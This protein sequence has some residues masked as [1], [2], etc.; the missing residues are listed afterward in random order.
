LVIHYSLQ[1]MGGPN[2]VIAAKLQRNL[3]GVL[4]IWAACSA[5]AQAAST[6]WYNGDLDNRDAFTNQTSTS[7]TGVDSLVY[8]DFIVPAGQ[9]WTITSA[10][11]N[12]VKNPFF[13]IATPT[14]VAWQI[15]SGMSAGNAG[16][17]VAS[18][19]ATGSNVTV[20]ADGTSAVFAPFS[21][22]QDTITAKGLSVVLTAGTYYLSVAPVTNGG[23]DGAWNISTTSG[24]NA[25]GN[26]KG[27]DG[28]SYDESIAYGN[29]YTP[30]S[31]TESYLDEGST[32]D[33]SM[34]VAG[35]FIVTPEP[36]S[37]VLMLAASLGLPALGFRRRKTN[38]SVPQE[39]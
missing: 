34:G 5:P 22:T 38:S 26:P 11:S 13:T 14:Q 20:A 4:F 21:A 28:N 19:I 15:H 8:D 3:L 31:I 36:S 37:M 23:T 25:I 39:L 7:A 1:F 12:D 16:T 33:Y 9:K 6:L 2:T 27:N 32:W 35:T 24:L 29:N 17:V 10:W 18:G 30:S